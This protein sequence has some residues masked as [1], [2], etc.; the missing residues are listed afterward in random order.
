MQLAANGEIDIA[1]GLAKLTCSYHAPTGTVSPACMPTPITAWGDSWH[2]YG[3]YRTATDV[4]VYWDGNLEATVPTTDAEGPQA[5][6][7]N[8]GVH[9]RSRELRVW[10]RGRHAGGLGTRLD[11]R[12]SGAHACQDPR[13]HS[14]RYLRNGRTVHPLDSFCP[15]VSR[16]GLA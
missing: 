13:A 3:A 1:E 2:V 16:R 8:I 6:R 4:Y 10:L 12:L 7:F 5:I 9:R 14:A 15:V 11:K